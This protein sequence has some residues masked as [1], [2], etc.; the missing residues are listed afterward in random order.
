LEQYI[1]NEIIK[2]ESLEENQP[3]NKNAIKAEKLKAEMERLNAMFRKGRIEE[4]EYDTEYFK[5]EKSLKKLDV[6]EE[7][8]KRDLDA[9]KGILETDYRGIY[10]QLTKE[11]QKA[12][13]RSF[14]REFAIDENKKIVPESIIFF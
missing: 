10:A 2:V 5:L 8:P 9:L 11:N 3:E 12:F 4:E 6:T 7:P 14:I 1:T 13:W